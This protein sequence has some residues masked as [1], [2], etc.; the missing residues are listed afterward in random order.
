MFRFNRTIFI[1]SNFLL[2]FFSFLI[3]YLIRYSWFNFT[4]VE[5]R[6]INFFTIILFLLYSLTIIILNISLKSYEINKISRLTESILSNIFISIL[7]IGIFGIYFYLT[8]TNFARFVFFLG[9]FFIPF[10]LS[11]F[12]KLIF[13]IISRTKNPINIL[14]FGSNS[15]YLIFQELVLEYK[16]W[17]SMKV[18]RISQDE[19]INKIQQK[20]KLSDLLVVDT[21]QKFKD[22]YVRLLNNYEIEGGKIYSL[23]DMFAYFDQSLPAEII[24]NK[25]Y[26]FFSAYKIDSI[27]N[28]FIK[29]LIDIIFSIILILILSPVIIL[30]IIT[31]KISSPGKIF[32]RQVRSTLNGKKFLIY[33]FRSMKI[34]DRKIKKQFTEKND[35][36]ITPV[37]K[38]IRALRIDEIPQLINVLVGDMSLIGPRPELPEITEDI[39]Q[40]FPLFKKR[41]LIKPGL[42]GWAQVKYKYVNKI[43]K[44]NKKLSYDLYYINNLSFIFDLKI[45]LYTI[46]TVLFRRGA[47]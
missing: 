45:F 29:R 11:F 47:I 43:E 25:H 8:Q 23:I 4:N 21:D 18:S 46:E 1:I 13:I 41:L 22:S 20:I 37:G 7:S 27:Y 26:E 39:S 42:T 16:K 40:K 17:F 3:I 10:L 12:N 44:M 30:T 5:K 15:N 14:Y 9:F 19:D 34:N 32:F 6:T 24:A 33:K 35:I 38:I 28:I 36:R 31:I 2:S